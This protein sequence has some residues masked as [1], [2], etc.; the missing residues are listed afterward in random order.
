MAVAVI[1]PSFPAYAPVVA[2]GRISS[3]DGTVNSAEYLQLGG[4]GGSGRP[5]ELATWASLEAVRPKN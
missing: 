5:G 2:M 1:N 3:F 4:G